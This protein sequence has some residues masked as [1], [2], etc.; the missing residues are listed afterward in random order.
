MPERLAAA[1]TIGARTKMPTS[2]KTGMP[3]MRPVRPMASGARFS[4]NRLSR[5]AESASAP[6]DTSRIAPSIVPR[7]MMIATWP[8]MPPMPDSIIETE[9]DRWTVPKSSVT[10]RP[11]ERPTAMDTA[12]SATNGC[13]LTLMIRTRS[14]T[15]PRAAT[16]SRPAVPSMRR[17]RPPVWGGASGVG[18]AAS[19]DDMGGLFLRAWSF[20][21]GRIAVRRPGGGRRTVMTY[22]VRVLWGVGSVGRVGGRRVVGPR[23]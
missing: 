16:V 14:R 19:R 3:K 11:A 13:S 10:E 15:M 22:G 4:P 1:Y 7:P 2:K 18:V 21:A 9:V 23:C 5:R 12:S 17:S 6:P 8:R 20:R